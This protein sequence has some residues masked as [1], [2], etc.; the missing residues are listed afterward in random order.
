MRRKL[1]ILL[2]AL[3]VAVAC[4]PFAACGEKKTDYGTLT[5]E[6]ITLTEG[7]QTNVVYEFSIPEHAD[8]ISYEFE[9]TDIEIENDV[10][11]AI[12]GGAV[13]TVTAKTEHHETTFTVTTL[14]DYG[15][16]TIEDVTVEEGETVALSP[17]FSRPAKAEDITYEFEGNDI[18][19]DGGYVTALVGGK[20]V[21]VTAKTEH[22][23]TTFTVTTAEV[24]YGTLTIS[25]I[26]GLMTTSNP[27]KIRAVFSVPSR[28]EE[29]TYTFEGNDIKIENGY[30]TALV[31]GKTVE[32]T[33]K[34]EHHE[35]TFT[36]TTLVDYGALYIE[37]VFAW[38]DYPASEFTAE[39]E[40]PEYA[41]DLVYSYDETKLSIDEENMTITVKEAG[42]FVV[43]VSAENFK[44]TFTV[45]GETVNKNDSVFDTSAY[46]AKVAGYLDDWNNKGVNGS[47]TLFIGDSF[48]DSGFWTNFYSDYAG[49]DVLRAG[50]SSSTSY[51][52]EVFTETYLKHTSPKNIAM[53]VGTNNIYDDGKDA[54]QTISALQRMFYVIHETLP[55]THIY[56]FNISQRT[57]DATKQGIVTVVN[58]TMEEWCANR[59]WITLID[60]S[61]RLTGDMLKDSVHPKPE[62]YYIFVDALAETDIVINDAPIEEGIG[63]TSGTFDAQAGTFAKQSTLPRTRSYLKDGAIEYNG[64]FAIS[65]TAKISG[66]GNNPWVEL[67]INK[68]PADDWFSANSALPVSTIVF[69]NTQAAEIWGYNSGGSK[70]G[71]TS[72]NDYEFTFTVVAF[73]DSVLFKVDEEVIVYTDAAFAGNKYFAFGAENASLSVSNLKIIVNDDTAVRG[74]YDENAPEPSA[75]IDDIVRVQAQAINDGASAVVYKGEQLN[76][77]YVLQGKLDVTGSG[78]NAHVH[79]KF[80]GD[81]GRILLWDN[82]TT[83]VFGLGWACGDYVGGDL[84]PAE[85]KFTLAEG[86]PISLD[87]KLVVTENDAYFYINGELRLVWKGVPGNTITLSSEKTDCKFYDMSALTLTADKEAYEAEIAAMQEVI[88]QYADLPAGVNRV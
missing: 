4:V 44:T 41:E 62:N 25:D 64:N 36:V 86:Q 5:V 28:A 32:V 16:L 37:D 1:A 77:N 74:V 14:V 72:I 19:I 81:L 76:R 82:L 9:G 29:I 79:W 58:D 12:K 38:V 65:G 50:V 54:Q 20:T 39:F 80:D 35:T 6:D 60:T 75:V 26:T 59:S 2:T 42:E 84:A 11:T 87:W 61:S 68:T 22:H 24:D 63:F 21:E 53:H 7:E 3:L 47:T 34:T 48:F 52:W 85:D 13:V 8:E 51:D 83:K 71:I 15:T 17:Q 66:L 46:N 88:E 45:Y 56:Y 23:E 69:Y 18:K 30:V 49:K 31:G 43:S 78:E 73:G 10:V 70:T 40:Y 33:A 27:A 55:E 67:L 57:Y